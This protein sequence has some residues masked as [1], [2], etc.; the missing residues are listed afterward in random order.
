MNMWDMHDGWGWWMVIGWIWMIVFWGLIIWAVY[1]I[2]SRLG[3]SGDH[4]AG[5]SKAIAILEERFARGEITREEF[6]EMRG[7][8]TG[9]QRQQTPPG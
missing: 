7:A 6:D 5:G 1:A 9:A 8:L 4:K 3:G 2:V